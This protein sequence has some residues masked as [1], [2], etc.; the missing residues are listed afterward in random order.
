MRVERTFNIDVI[1]T[2]LKHPAVKDCIGDDFSGDVEYPI[3]DNLYYLAVYDEVI[4]GM[5]VVYPLNRVTFDGHSAMLPGFYGKK[6][7]EAGRLAIDWVF[8]NTDCLKINGSTPVYN[9]LALR[10]SKT[11]GFEQEGVNKRS[12]MKDGEL[13]DQIYFGLERKKWALS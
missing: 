4:A 6:A 12:I 3:V 11:I 8:N 2:V 7:K 1:N 13:H 10:Y 5:F 9:K